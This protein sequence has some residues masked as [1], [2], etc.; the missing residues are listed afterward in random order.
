MLPLRMSRIALHEPAR[1]F[2]AMDGCDAQ[3]RYDDAVSLDLAY[4]RLSE[5]FLFE[6]GLH[7]VVPN[8]AAAWAGMRRADDP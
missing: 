5:S 8:E 3:K 7:Q 4:E 6:E 2:A 1:W